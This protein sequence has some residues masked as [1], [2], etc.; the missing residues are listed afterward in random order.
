MLPR[1]VKNPHITMAQK[2]LH[3]KMHITH[4]NFSQTS[5]YT[6]ITRAILLKLKF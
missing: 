5:V 6:Q 3:F 1:N 2:K 4:S